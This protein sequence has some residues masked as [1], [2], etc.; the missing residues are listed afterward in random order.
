MPNTR[1]YVSHR[2]N[3]RSIPVGKNVLCDIVSGSALPSERDF[4][5]FARDDVGD[6]ISAEADKFCE[7]SALYW[8]WKND[9][10]DF[11]LIVI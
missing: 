5:L 6:N 11:L 8:M 7:F 2:R 10:S 1:I 9:D 3:G 4:R